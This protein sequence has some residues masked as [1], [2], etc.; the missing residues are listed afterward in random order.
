MKL[1]KKKVA[2]IAS[3]V[4]II[5]ILSMGSLAWFSDE[6]TITNTLKFATDEE[7]GETDFGVDVYE[8]DGET[9][10]DD[11]MVYDKLL[12]NQKIAKAPIIENDGQYKEWVYFTVTVNHTEIFGKY[13]EDAASFA[14]LFEGFNPDLWDNFDS[15]KDYVLDNDNHTITYF[16]YSKNIF[17][18]GDKVT[19]F[20]N[21]TVPKELTVEDANAMANSFTIE[22]HAEAVQAENLPEGCDTAKEAFALLKESN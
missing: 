19:L 9:K 5:A 3:I 10:K 13:Y 8:M 7:T 20:T 12:P 15:S 16:G 6:D 17:N 1:S 14:A 11:G 2:A 21:F 18:P 4:C 22:V